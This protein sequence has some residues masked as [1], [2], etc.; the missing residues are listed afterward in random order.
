MSGQLRSDVAGTR[1]DTLQA[2]EPESRRKK[3]KPRLEATP[4]AEQ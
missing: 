1:S 4:A 3:E 2:S